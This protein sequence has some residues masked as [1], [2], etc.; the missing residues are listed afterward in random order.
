[1]A[2]TLSPGVRRLFEAPNFAH[3]A[4]LMPDGSPQVTP[5]WVDIDGDRILVNTAEGRAKPRNVRRDPRVAISITDRNNHYS[6]ALIRGRVVG[7]THEGADELIDKLAQKYIGQERYP[8]R[9]P[10][11]R[12]VTLVI[13]PEHVTSSAD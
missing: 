5:V 12:R 13:E 9:R 4:T 2:I 7:I 11:E 10:E 3:L 6:A 1:M 8:W